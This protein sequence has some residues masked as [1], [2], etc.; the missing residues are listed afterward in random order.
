MRGCPEA[1]HLVC[2]D[3]SRASTSPHASARRHGQ[4]QQGW[5]NLILRY[6]TSVAVHLQISWSATQTSHLCPVPTDTQ[7]HHPQNCADILCVPLSYTV[8][9][10]AIHNTRTHR[11]TSGVAMASDEVAVVTV[12]LRCMMR[13]NLVRPACRSKEGI[14]QHMRLDEGEK[15]RVG[16]MPAFCCY[17]DAHNP[18]LHIPGTTSHQVK[19]FG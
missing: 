8:L 19:R 12:D 4:C 7:A 5:F 14:E 2:S 17:K 15:A 18:P 3:L 1:M 9:Y 6:G 10:S 13:R 16:H 11:G